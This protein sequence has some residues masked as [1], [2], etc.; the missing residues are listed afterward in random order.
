[1]VWIVLQLWRMRGGDKAP[2]A[3]KAE[4]KADR[5]QPLSENGG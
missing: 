3:R 5:Y 1:M 2:P 4:V